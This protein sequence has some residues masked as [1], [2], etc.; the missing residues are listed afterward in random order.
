MMRLKIQMPG[1]LIFFSLLIISVFACKKKEADEPVV[2]TAGTGGSTTLIVELRHHDLLIPNDSV[3]PDTVWI[4]YNAVNAGAGYDVRKI[5]IV[6]DSNV[7]F[8]NLKCG[9]YF[10]TASGYDRSIGFDVT[11]GLGITIAENAD[12]VLATVPVVE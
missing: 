4:K 2:C 6:G 11:G 12:T 1:K 7:I 3:K 5:G 9:N 8:N 10:L